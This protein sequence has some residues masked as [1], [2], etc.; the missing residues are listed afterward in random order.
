MKTDTAAPAADIPGLVLRPY[1]GEADIPEIVRHPERGVGGRRHAWSH[2]R[3]RLRRV[4]G[5]PERASS[6]RP[7]TC[8]SPSSTAGWWH[9][10]SRDWVDTTDGLRE[11]RSGGAVDPAFRRRGIGSLHARRPDRRRTSAATRRTRTSIGRACSACGSTSATSGAPRSAERSGYEPA[12]WFF[13]MERSHR[14]R[15][16]RRSSRFP[17]ASS[18]G[19]CPPTRRGSCGRP[20]TRRSAT[21][22]AATTSRRRT[23]DAGGSRRSSTR[24]MFLVAWDG[25]EIAGGVLNADLP[26]ARTR[27]SACGAAGWTACSRAGRGAAAGW[28]ATSSCARSTSCGSAE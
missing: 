18:F 11:Y 17:T 26:R 4:V 24:R 25:D 5:P 20:T 8:G 10:P 14:G 12:R 7:A 28:P 16:A 27:H 23:S 2:D 1:A 6:T 22:G 3:R 21:T 15:P 9:S 13:D 19:R